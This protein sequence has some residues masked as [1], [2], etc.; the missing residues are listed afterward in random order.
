MPAKELVVSFP[1]S[2]V[3]VASRSTSFSAVVNFHGARGSRHDWY[4]TLAQILV[5]E[6][7]IHR[8]GSTGE[9]NINP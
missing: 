7:S 6:G 4:S 5:V 8:L 1:V 9:G 3:Y 2:I